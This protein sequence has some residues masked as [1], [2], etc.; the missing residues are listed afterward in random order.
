[1][2]IGPIEKMKKIDNAMIEI[3]SRDVVILTESYKLVF[4]HLP[5]FY[6]DEAAHVSIDL[7]KLGTE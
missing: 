7:I 3:L 1:M 5:I 2:C 6:I 4:F